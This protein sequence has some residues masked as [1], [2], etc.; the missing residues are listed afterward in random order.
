[1]AVNQCANTIK[2]FCTRLTLR[3]LDSL[4]SRTADEYDAQECDRY[5]PG[6][7]PKNIVGLFSLEALF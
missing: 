3:T 6:C 1:M 5:Q 4:R 2:S 7:L